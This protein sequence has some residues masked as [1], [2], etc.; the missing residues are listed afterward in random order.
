MVHFGLYLFMASIQPAF[1]PDATGGEG[2][3][4]VFWKDVQART[5]AEVERALA[6]NYVGVTPSGSARRAATIEST[7]LGS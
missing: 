1:Y 2:L 4:R 5:A 3:E 7:A 6:S